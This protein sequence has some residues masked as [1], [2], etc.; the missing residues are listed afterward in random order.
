M[1]ETSTLDVFQFHSG[2]IKSLI[3]PLMIALL[4]LFQFHSGLIKRVAMGRVPVRLLVRFNSIL[5]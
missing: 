1:L 4:V 5:V 3:I 2:L